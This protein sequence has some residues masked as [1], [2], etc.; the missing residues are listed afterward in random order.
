[1]QS[2]ADVFKREIES[3]TLTR[4]HKQFVECVPPKSTHQAGN[5]IFKGK[6]GRPFVGKTQKGRQV[7]NEL[8]VL[9]MRHRPKEMF[10]GALNVEICF[11]YPF[12]KTERNYNKQKHYLPHIVRPDLD[13]LAKG[14]LD[15]M[16]RARYFKDDAQICKLTLNKSYNEQTGIGIDMFEYTYS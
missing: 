9:M 2:C 16:Q 5:A 7:A 4:T 14:I 1:M 15:A 3:R 8:F 10:L 11:V 6:N 12:K 13:N